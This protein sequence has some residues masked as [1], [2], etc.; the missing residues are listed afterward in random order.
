MSA[1]T[2]SKSKAESKSADE[3]QLHKE[4]EALKQENAELKNRLAEYQTI[5]DSMPIMFW[6]KDTENRNVRVNRAAAELERSSVEAIEGKSAYDLYP[7]DQAAA[8]H[9]DDLEV[10][11]AGKPKLNIIEKHSSPVTGELMWVQT[12]KVPYRD[13]EGQV[14]GVIAFAVDITEQKRA[15][16]A[17]QEAH[18][19]MQKQHQRINRANEFFRYTLE[20]LSNSVKLGGPKDEL[21]SYI[22]SA[23]REF[24]RLDAKTS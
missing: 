5:F 9:K 18:Q 8:Y 19:E 22:D 6:Y 11:Q 21:L 12:G 14:V 4:I 20:Q 17:L 23:K 2:G 13:K 16:Q 3:D 1:K 10:I 15:E 7:H 24:E